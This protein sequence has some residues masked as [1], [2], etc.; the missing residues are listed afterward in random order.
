MANLSGNITGLAIC[1]GILSAFEALA[2]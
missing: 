1:M 2:P